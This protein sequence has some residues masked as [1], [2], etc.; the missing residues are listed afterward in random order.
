MDCSRI[1]DGGIDLGMDE[2]PTTS[3]VAWPFLVTPSLGI[4]TGILLDSGSGIE[5]PIDT[6]GPDYW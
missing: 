1:G 3:D 5:S 6:A 2:G 4:W